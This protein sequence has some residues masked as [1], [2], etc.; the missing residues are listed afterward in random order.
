V[1]PE[2]KEMQ[3]VQEL[4]QTLVRDQ[5]I[6]LATNR[7]LSKVYEWWLEQ[8]ANRERQ[9]RHRAKK[10]DQQQGRCR[11]CGCVRSATI[12]GTAS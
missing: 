4:L 6:L 11:A 5:R 12:R 3:R 9:T 2:K 10:G 7:K 1:Y 8:H